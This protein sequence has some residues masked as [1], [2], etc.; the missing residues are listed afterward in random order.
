MDGFLRIIYITISALIAII[1]HE[2]AHG[3]ISHRLGD[4]TPKSTGRLSMNPFNH[5][6]PIGLISLIIFGFG[7]AKPVRVNPY[8]YKNKKGGM[9]LVAL[10]GPVT[11]FLIALIALFISGLIYK[12][13]NYEI[14]Y[15]EDFIKILVRI[16]IGL[17]MFNL[18]P[19]PPLDGSKI[20]GA[21]L[22]EKVYFE[23]MRYERYGFFIL[24]ALLAFGI[25]NEPLSKALNFIEFNLSQIVIFILQ[26]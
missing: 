16:N 26:L 20:I 14:I 4:P 9:A 8:Y 23:Y 21:V 22:P 13:S 25:L 10:A 3:Y 24:I 12:L 1:F 7:W 19:I 15:H 17:G 18:I 11:N 2:M 6:D 5:L